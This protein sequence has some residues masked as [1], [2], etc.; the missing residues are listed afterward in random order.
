MGYIRILKKDGKKLLLDSS[1][2]YLILL[3]KD[4]VKHIKTENLIKF[5]EDNGQKI[6]WEELRQ[7]E[8]ELKKLKEKWWKNYKK[9]LPKNKEGGEQC[10]TKENK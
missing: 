10:F 5:L 9:T 2:S 3:S 6:S 7:I 1:M 8:T 4:E